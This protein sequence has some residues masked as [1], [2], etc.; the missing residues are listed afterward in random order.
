M[1]ST[2]YLNY[3]ENRFYVYF[4]KEVPENFICKGK[5]RL[6]NNS[7]YLGLDVDCHDE[8]HKE[9]NIYQTDPDLEECET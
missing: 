2:I 8:Q 3:T 6:K 1:A 9:V 7:I 5:K 4:D